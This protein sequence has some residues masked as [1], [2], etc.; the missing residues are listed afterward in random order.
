MPPLFLCAGF[1]RP[2]SFWPSAAL[3]EQITDIRVTL[4]L[5][6]PVDLE[7]PAD[8]EVPV[9]LE[10]PASVVTVH[11]KECAAASAGVCCSACTTGLVPCSIRGWLQRYD[12]CTCVG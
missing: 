4:G 11:T 12:S 3:E 8:L 10:V 7:V 1:T 6:E 5:E 9:D 2:A